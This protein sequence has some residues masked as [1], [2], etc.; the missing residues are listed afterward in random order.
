MP[1][2]PIDPIPSGERRE[3]ILAYNTSDSR[4]KLGFLLMKYDSP[5]LEY[6]PEDNI[7]WKY[8]EEGKVS[9]QK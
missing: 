9:K 3:M 8:W 2:T 5:V 6:I 4:Y 7:F 1:I